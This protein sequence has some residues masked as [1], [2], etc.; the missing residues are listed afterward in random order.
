MRIKMDFVT[1]HGDG[2]LIFK[3]DIPEELRAVAGRTTWQKMLRSRSWNS[4]VARLHRRYIAESE[5]D[6]A[7]WRDQS[8][9][10][11]VARPFFWEFEISRPPGVDLETSG[12]YFQALTSGNDLRELKKDLVA[13]G[14]LPGR[15]AA[16][17]RLAGGLSSFRVCTKRGPASLPPVGSETPAP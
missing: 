3:R 11:Q 5:R 10:A 6:L 14:V 9:T 8:G 17:S 1:T 2:R 13:A 7:R 4:T 15:V 16:T 12:A